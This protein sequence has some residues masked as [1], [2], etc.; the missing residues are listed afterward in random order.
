MDKTIADSKYWLEKYTD[1]FK[2]HDIRMTE[3]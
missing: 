3:I 1:G 2:E